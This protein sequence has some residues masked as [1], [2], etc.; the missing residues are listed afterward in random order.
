MPHWKNQIWAKEQLLGSNPTLSMNKIRVHTAL[1]LGVALAKAS[2]FF[3]FETFKT[4]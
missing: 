4:G 1:A 3:V 2:I